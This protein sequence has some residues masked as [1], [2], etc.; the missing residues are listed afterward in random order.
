MPANHKPMTQHVRWGILG[1]A[2]IAREA[3]IPAMR[4]S[5]YDQRLELTAIASR[6]LERAQLVAESHGIERAY[7][8]YDA[9]LADPEIDAVYIPLPNHLHVPLSIRALEAGKH[10][11]CEKP[12]ALSAS[13]A[14]LLHAAAL[15]HPQLKVME[16]FMYR[17]HPQWQWLRQTVN[18]GAIGAVQT[19]QAFFSFF[20]DNPASILHQPQW[21]GGSLLDIGCY[22]VSLARFVFDA[23]PT[24][25]LGTWKID[26]RFGVDCLTSAIMEFGAGMATFTSATCASPF[27]QVQVLGTKGRIELPAPFN[28]SCDEGCRALLETGAG[29]REIEFDLCDQY[30]I[31]ADLFSRAILNDAAMPISLDDSVLNARVIDAIARSAQSGASE[32]P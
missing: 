17:C 22:G 5:P 24:R 28:P 2:T 32:R 15:Q 13:E 31:Q 8:S 25:V 29:V 27:Q 3:V 10:V 4:K 9:L 20:D 26:D 7:G 30:G 14:R 1:T 6:S 19:V 18:S 16:A 21:G 12:L 11:L 23:E